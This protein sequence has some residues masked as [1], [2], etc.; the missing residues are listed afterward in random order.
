[1]KTPDTLIVHPLNEEQLNVI[2]TILEVLKVKFE[3]SKDETYNPDFV[4]KIQ[5]ARQD[6]KDGKGTVYTSDQL[7]ALWK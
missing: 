2:K 6:Y 4:A 3:F 1:M 5:K 7:N